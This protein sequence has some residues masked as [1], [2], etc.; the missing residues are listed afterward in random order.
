MEKEMFNKDL[1]LL[2]KAQQCWDG[3]ESFRLERQRN[4]RY[5]YGDQWGDFV[6]VD[7]HRMRE[8]EYIR[9]QGSEPLKNNLIRRLVKQVLGLYRADKS[10]ILCEAERQRQLAKVMTKALEHNWKVNRS[11]ELNAR[12]LEE[13]LISGLAVQRKTYGLRNGRTDCWTDIVSPACFFFD[14][15][16]ADC[17]GWDAEMVGEIHD[18]RFDALASAFATCQQQWTA[19]ADIYSPATYDERLGDMKTQ[20]GMPRMTNLDF[21]R[22]A[23]R[24]MCRVVEVWYRSRR[25][26][27][28]CHDRADGT[29]FRI[30][31]GEKQRLV[32]EA[33]RR[34]P[35]PLDETSRRSLVDM[36]FTVVD[37]WR[38]AYLSPFG[39]VLAEGATPYWHGSHPYVFK[40]YPFVDAEIHSFVADIIDQQ[41]Y[42]NRLITLYDWVMR[43]SAKGVLLVPEESI[44]EGYS[45]E[46]IADEWA[47][48]NG[49]IAVKT[50]N[51][52]V[53]PQ[54]VSANAVNV[55]I[56]ELLQTQLSFMED[57]S[58]VTGAL[59]GKA[60]GASVSGTLFEQQTRN[61]TLSQLDLLDTFRS[62]V[63]DGAYKD[64]SNIRQFYTTPR[65]YA[66]HGNDSPVVYEPQLMRDQDAFDLRFEV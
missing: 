60:T 59:Q 25:P 7:G 5:C 64:I 3:M 23:D 52:A 55:G 44:P 10:H 41:R 50:R 29:L 4:L 22:T 24:E 43:S 32:D 61:A 38:Y 35:N 65:A 46:D 63:L 9:S 62:F 21:F 15:A 40:A 28:L 18:M 47:R 53:L 33:N 26:A 45:I 57:I 39:D 36:Q 13:F 16:A 31:A 14:S 11:G 6:A 30:D 66:S 2:A 17:R 56:H 48:F 51:G 20:Q 1:R 8:D 37:Q 54:Q 49:V 19:L 12:L 42:T 27:F 34:S 58:G